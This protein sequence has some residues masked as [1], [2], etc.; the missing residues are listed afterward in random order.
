MLSDL[1]GNTTQK[2]T[3]LQSPLTTVAEI[4]VIVTCVMLIIWL[5]R[6]W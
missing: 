6:H 3:I 2:M 5:I 1:F 4:A